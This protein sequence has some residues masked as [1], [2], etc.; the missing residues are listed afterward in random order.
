MRLKDKNM[1]FALT[2]EWASRIEELDAY[3]EENQ[4]ANEKD[5]ATA[6]KKAMIDC[7]TSLS[8]LVWPE[9]AKKEEVSEYQFSEQDC[10]F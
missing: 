1:I 3:I 10:P 5:N 7:L 8:N 6:Y 4:D 2:E 9:D